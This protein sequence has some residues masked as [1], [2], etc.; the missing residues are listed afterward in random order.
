MDENFRIGIDLDA[1]KLAME[2]AMVRNI[3]KSM[4]PPEERACKETFLGVLTIFER[5]N[6]GAIECLDIM[7][8]LSTFLADNPPKGGQHD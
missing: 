7:K 8:E 2:N 5:H 6:I 1:L 4:M 3:I